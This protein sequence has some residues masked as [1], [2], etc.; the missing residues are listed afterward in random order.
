MNFMARRALGMLPRLIAASMLTFLLLNLLPGDP[1]ITILGPAAAIPEARESLRKKLA[2]DKPIPVRYVKWL[3]NVVLHGDL[4]KSYARNIPVVTEIRRKF[5]RTLE[6]MIFAIGVSLIFA[7]PL[8]VWSAYRSGTRSDGVING[9]ATIFIGV[10]GYVLGIVAL[11]LFAVKFRTF[12][13]SYKPA[14]QYGYLLHFR[15]LVMPVGV[16]AAGLIP[17]FIRVL[18]TEMVGTLSEDFITMARS[19]GISDRRILVRH[20]LR[21]SSF[22]LMTVAGLNVG[23]LIGGALIVENIFQAQGLGTYLVVSTFQREYLNVQ[24]CV[25]IVT[26]GYVLVNFLVEVLYGVLDPRIRH[27]RAIA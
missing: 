15:S 22:A 27:A 19:K 5:P 14:N 21:P 25:L 9:I 1:S 24:G 18:R 8:G 6:L 10:P 3:G 16:L 26:V 20:A 7:I 12:P 23:A 4:G 11:F 2:L 13:A 17:I